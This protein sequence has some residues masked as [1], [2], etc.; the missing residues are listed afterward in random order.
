[1]KLAAHAPGCG[2]DFHKRCAFKIPSDCSG[3]RRRCGPSLS[4]IPTGRTRATSLS[5]Q[6][7]GSLEE[8]S[9][10]KP[11]RRCRAPSWGGRPVWVDHREP[12]RVQVPHRFHIHTYTRPTVCQHC[13]RLLLGLFRQGLQC[14][15]CKFNCHKRCLPLL[16]S[17]CVGERGSF[18]GEEAV[19]SL[20]SA[21]EFLVRFLGSEDAR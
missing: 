9:R 10:S 8:I 18:N 5:T 21:L 4:L 20:K 1:M 12:T 19:S 7:G 17:D 16:P 11:S 6:T 3:A 14:S 2:L 15:D 13:Q